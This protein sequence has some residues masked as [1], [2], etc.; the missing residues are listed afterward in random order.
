MHTAATSR[1]RYM[2][3]SKDRGLLINAD[4]DADADPAAPLPTDAADA[5]ATTH[6]ARY[7]HSTQGAAHLTLSAPIGRPTNSQ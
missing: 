1:N 3:S 4:A 2:Y 6:L 5:T 7:Q